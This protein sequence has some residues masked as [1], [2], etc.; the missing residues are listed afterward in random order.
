MDSSYCAARIIGAR[1]VATALRTLLGEQVWVDA[2]PASSDGEAI[3]DCRMAS[4]SVIVVRHVDGGP[5]YLGC[6]LLWEHGDARTL[7]DLLRRA[8]EGGDREPLPDAV[9][10]R[11]RT[12][13]RNDPSA[14]GARYWQ[15]LASLMI[16]RASD[17]VNAPGPWQRS[18]RELAE[19]VGARL[20]ERFLAG[21]RAAVLAYIGACWL[22]TSRR[23]VGGTVQSLLLLADRRSRPELKRVAG[24][25]HHWLPL[26]ESLD[27]RIQFSALERAVAAAREIGGRWQEQI[28][29]DFPPIGTGLE[30]RRVRAHRGRGSRMRDRRCRWVDR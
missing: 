12:A 24:H 2:G 21:G 30:R 23:A 20:D 25:T 29:D 22:V 9:L 17:E 7:V 19:E 13:I 10:E 14:A 27:D 8:I 4:P 26:V 1:D 28:P 18:R 15:R 3:R 16:T 6:A 11:W 5:S